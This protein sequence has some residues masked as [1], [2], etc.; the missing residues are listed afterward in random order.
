MRIFRSR[1]SKDFFEKD[2]SFK[3]KSYKDVNFWD[4][5]IELI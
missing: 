5:K 4:I 2:E 3:N 1:R